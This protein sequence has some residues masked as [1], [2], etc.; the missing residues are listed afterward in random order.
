M[1]SHTASII[2]ITLTSDSKREYQVRDRQS[3]C[4]VGR[5]KWEP[6]MLHA[7][8]DEQGHLIGLE[9]EQHRR[10]QWHRRHHSCSELSM[11]QFPFTSHSYHFRR[12]SCI[13]TGVPAPS[14]EQPHAQC[15]SGTN[16]ERLALKNTPM[17]TVKRTRPASGITT[18]DRPVDQ[19][20]PKTA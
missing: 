14:N 7:D 15:F 19:S 6:F 9:D 3:A 1:R 16:G 5:G 17:G 18:P 8:G 13:S 2:I 10:S 12:N 11:L 20:R 4:K